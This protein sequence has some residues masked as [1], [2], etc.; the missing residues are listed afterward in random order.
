MESAPS[1]ETVINGRRY[2]YF[3]GTS[4]FGLHADQDLMKAGIRAWRKLGH[5]T[6]TSRAGMGTSPIY[7][8]V[9]QE[10]AR[11]LGTD[12]AAYLPSG[13]LS[14]M[15]G[16]R[17]LHEAGK[18]D[19]IFIDEH[20]HF[21]AFDAALA[22]GAPTHKIAHKVP[23][24]LE[25]KLKTYLRPGQKPLMLSDS[26]FPAL[27][28]IA[29]V[30]EI[31]EILEPYQGLLWLDEAHTLGV[32]GPNGRGVYDHFNLAGERLFSGGTMA[33]AFGGFGGVIPGTGSL[34]NSVMD[35]HVMCGASAVPPPLAA[36][37]L[38][39]I[40]LLAANPQWR[41]RL[42]ANGRLLKKGIMSLGLEVEDSDVP[43]AA[44]KLGNSESMKYV[45]RELLNRGIAIQHTNYA[46]VDKGGVLRIVVFSTHTSDQI[47]HLIDELGQLV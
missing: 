41:T 18:F 32:L 7:L 8:R 38:S 17:A 37:T 21:S 36:A 44:F 4:Y 40:E 26:I 28:Q 47:Q 9:E 31:V 25:L 2:L 16:L 29:L 24:D 10:A 20:S 45:H 43:I 11:F 13:Y 34:I 30:P 3:G 46:G 35:G 23:D 19:V 27:G 39:G 33:K 12:S 1:T 22:T 5:S 42:W 15:A 6:A 14:N